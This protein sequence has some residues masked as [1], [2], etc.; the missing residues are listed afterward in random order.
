MYFGCQLSP[1]ED[2]ERETAVATVL[3]LDFSSVDGDIHHGAEGGGGKE[4]RK[5]GRKSR[6][7]YRFG[8]VRRE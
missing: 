2:D 1:A 4:E 8:G 5:E 6:D 3:V 7:R